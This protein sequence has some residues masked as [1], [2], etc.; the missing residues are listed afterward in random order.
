M[1][2]DDQKEKFIEEYLRS[3]V[4]A[5]TSLYAIFKKTEK[6]EEKLDKDVSEFNKDE[7]LL[8]LKSFH[9]K[10]I[11]S[12]LNYI[13][14]LK[15]YSRWVTG[16]VGQNDYEL[17]SKKDVEN[18]VDKNASVLITREDLDEI[19]ENLLNWS[20]KAIV[21][22]LWEGIA[23]KNMSDI[24]VVSEKCVKGE[25]LYI[26]G[27]EFFIT[28]RLAYLLPKAF[29]ETEIISY[30]NAMRIIQVN[31]K[32]RLYKERSNA[33]GVDTED[34]VFRYFYRKIQL[35]RNYLG[36]PNLTM[37]DLQSSGLFHY[38]QIGIKESGLDIRGFL[39]TKK[40]KELAI[41]YGFSED[42]YIDNIISKYEQYI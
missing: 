25:T 11:N 24:Y 16:T 39:K 40:G 29:A 38:L 37:K 32:G 42:Y 21:E 15:H 8:M 20:D 10:S 17:I 27:K 2:G 18:L 30:G 22:L 34:S 19:E 6:F 4:V 12:L 31:G 35:F 9:S 5:S 36:I 33:R 1:Y 13:V 41:K 28:D 26:N 23:G 3:K 7:I 14:I